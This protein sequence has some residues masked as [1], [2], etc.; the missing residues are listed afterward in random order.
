MVIPSWGNVFA[1]LGLRDADEKQTRVLPAIAINQIIQARLLSQT[2]A[3][4]SR[5]CGGG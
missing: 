1:D 4:A 3:V 5:H 2:A